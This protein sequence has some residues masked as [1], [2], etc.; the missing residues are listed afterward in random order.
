MSTWIAFARGM[1]QI[2]REDPGETV[3]LGERKKSIGPQSGRSNILLDKLD[4]GE[5]SSGIKR[6]KKRVTLR[7]QLCAEP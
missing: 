6:M 4:V 1:F 3:D 7:S 2:S 5:E